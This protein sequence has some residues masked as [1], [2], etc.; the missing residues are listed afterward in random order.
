ML[1]LCILIVTFMYSYCNVYVFL[2]LCVF[3][4]MYS[5]SVCC[6]VYCFVC[7]CVLYYCHRGSSQLQSTNITSCHILALVIQQANRSSM[8][9]IELL[10]VA[11]PAVPYFPTLSH[12]RHDFRN[13]VI[14]RKSM[15]WFS[16]QHLSE[17]FVILIWK[18]QNVI[19]V[20]R[21]SSIVPGIRVIFVYWVIILC[22]FLLPHE[23]CFTMCVLLSYIL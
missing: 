10:S 9:R 14:E 8:R 21:S 5:V 2:L 7:K 3:Y 16:L 13:K 15:F 4:S 23:Y 12:K 11:H 6:S 18:Q 22:L 19:N 20:H 1:C 17:K